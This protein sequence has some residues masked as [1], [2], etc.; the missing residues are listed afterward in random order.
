MSETRGELRFWLLWGV[1]LLLLLA[2]AIGG[3]AWAE[4]RYIKQYRPPEELRQY[5]QWIVYGLPLLSLLFSLIWLRRLALLQY[6]LWS[7]VGVLL[8][9]GLWWWFFHTLG[10]RWHISLG[11]TL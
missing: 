3:W 1:G 4:Y 10:V 2:A 9:S 8:T 5:T 11:G 6:L 7:L